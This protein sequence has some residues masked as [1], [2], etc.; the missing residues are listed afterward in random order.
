M[1]ITAGENH[2]RHYF[3]HFESIHDSAQDRMRCRE[4]DLEAKRGHVDRF[5]SWT[6][7]KVVAKVHKQLAPGVARDVEA[8]SA[9]RDPRLLGRSRSPKPQR[10]WDAG[11]VGS[12]A[13]ASRCGRLTH[14]NLN[15]QQ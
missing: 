5:L 11:A 12:E 8:P 15:K 4:S 2:H 3:Y 6:C 7:D 13:T 9:S 14:E 10:V 1:I